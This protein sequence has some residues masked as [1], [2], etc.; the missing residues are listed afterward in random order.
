VEILDRGFTKFC[1]FYLLGHFSHTTPQSVSE[2]LCGVVCR[3]SGKSPN[4]CSVELGYNVEEIFCVLIKGCD[5]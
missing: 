2:T 3:D 5:S 1:Q 4:K